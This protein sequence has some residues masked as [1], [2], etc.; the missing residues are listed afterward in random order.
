M[1]LR[2]VALALVVTPVAVL[3]QNSSAPVVAPAPVPL[4]I[5]TPIEA[6]AADPKGKL[7]LEANFPGM[8]ANP[9]YEQF[10]TMTLKQVQPMSGGRISE[11]AVAKT[12]A[13]LTAIK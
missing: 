13:D 6:I 11:A 3:A 12:Q 8:T 7:V 2:L 5:D 1:S 10:K 4:T 9:M